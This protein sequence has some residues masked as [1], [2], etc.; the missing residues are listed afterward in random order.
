[1]KCQLVGIKEVDYLSKKTGKQVTGKNLYVLYEAEN[2]R[3][4]VATDFYVNSEFVFDGISIGDDILVYFNQYGR[5]DE[6]EP[7]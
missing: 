4:Q 5:V 6:I 3:G 7:A 1:M 2:V